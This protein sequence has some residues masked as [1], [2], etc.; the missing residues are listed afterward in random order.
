MTLYSG[1][2]SLLCGDSVDATESQAKPERFDSFLNLPLDFKL[3]F[4]TVLML[5]QH[6]MSSDEHMISWKGSVLLFKQQ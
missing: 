6:G 1:L 5:M 4:I 2:Y 3:V